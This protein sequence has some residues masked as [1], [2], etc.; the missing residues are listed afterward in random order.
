[1]AFWMSVRVSNAWTC[2]FIEK[3]RTSNIDGSGGSRLSSAKYRSVPPPR[4]TPEYRSPRAS[5]ARGAQSSGV[6]LS[7]SLNTYQQ[8]MAPITSAG[9]SAKAAS[10]STSPLTEAM[11][12]RAPM[13]SAINAASTRCADAAVSDAEIATRR[14]SSRN[15]PR[16][17]MSASVIG[18]ESGAHDNPRRGRSV[19]SPVRRI[20]M[21]SSEM[22]VT[23][24][25]GCGPAS[26]STTISWSMSG[27]GTTSTG[28]GSEIGVQ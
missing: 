27:P 22:G 2:G 4:A 1:M 16:A 7:C 25:D 8:S 3:L 10:S 20:S 6:T 5:R 15:D 12:S 14:W 23:G 19:T 17:A 11:R 13:W 26:K 28:K 9:S 18:G 24:A 21:T